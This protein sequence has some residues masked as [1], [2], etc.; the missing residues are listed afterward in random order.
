MLRLKME[1]YLIDSEGNKVP[2]AEEL[3]EGLE[4]DYQRILNDV[5]K[6]L[7]DIE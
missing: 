1:E 5:K 7:E 6:L 3:I 4:E 2:T